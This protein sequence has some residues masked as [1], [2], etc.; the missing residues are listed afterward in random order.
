MAD[1]GGTSP[2]EL[3]GML[4]GA[5]AILGAAGA[6]A[7][8]VI[9]WLSG[10]EETR[11]TRNAAWERDLDAREKGLETRIAESLAR[12]EEHCATV[13]AK[14]DKVRIAI[15]LIL[16]ELQR[17]APYSPALK[18]VGVLLRDVFPISLDQP[19]DMA[20]GIAAIDAAAPDTN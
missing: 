1:T 6:A 11:S 13:D 9:G 7:K 20:A 8:W 12:C 2:G 14:F 16:P 5:L 10:R 4:A 3:G 18:R 17:A 15:L 19:D